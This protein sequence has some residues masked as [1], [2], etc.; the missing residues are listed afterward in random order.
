M[1]VVGL[2]SA[3]AE[4]RLAH[5]GPNELRA[6]GRSSVMAIVWRQVR[7]NFVLYLLAAAAVLSFVVEKP[8]TSYTIIAVIISVTVAGFIQEY[9]SEKATEA[10]KQLLV[11]VSIVRRN[12]KDME[13]FSRNIV[14][15]DVLVLR[16][17]EKIPADGIVVEASDLRVNES[18]LTG[19][20][21]DVS[22][23]VASD[24]HHPTPEQQIAMGTFVVYGRCLALVT[25]TGMNTKFGQISRSISESVKELPLQTKINRIAKFMVL[26]AL[27]VAVATGALMFSRADVITEEVV[28]TTLIFVIA[29]AISAFPE[30]FPVVVISTLA[31]GMRRMAK[32]NAIVNRMS[33]IETLGE[34]TVICSDKTGTIT[35]G[36][37]TVTEVWTEDHELAVTG[38]GYVGDGEFQSGTSTV[39]LKEYPGVQRLIHAAVA[40]NDAVIERTGD[41]MKFRVRGTATEAALLILGAKAGVYRDDLDLHRREEIPFNSERKMMSVIVQEGALMNVYAKGAPEMILARC[42]SIATT[43]GIRPID[44]TE[45]GRIL[46]EIHGFARRALR[47]LAIA[48]KSVA[49][50]T[51][52]HLEDGLTFLGFVGMEDTPREEV[53][54]AIADCRRAGIQVKMITG[55]NVETANAVAKQ[56]GLEGKAMVGAELE[57]MTDDELEKT[58]ES[59]SIFSRVKPEHKLRIIRALKARGHIVTMTGD[60]VNDAPALKDAHIGI[61]MG[62][63][64]TDVSR[65]VA[66][67]TLKDDNFSSIVAAVYEG[68]AI[69]KNIQKFVTYQLA[70]SIAA[71]LIL[72]FGLLF[73]PQLGWQTPILLA[74]QILFMNLVTDNLPAITLG[75]NPPSADLLSEQPRKNQEILTKSLIGLLVG[76]SVVLA[77]MALTANYIA[78]HWLQYDIV[79]ARTVAMVTLICLEISA[80]FTFRSFRKGVIGRS[81][82]V[83]RP[84]FIASV[85][86]MIATLVIIYTPFRG[87]FETA[88]IGLVGWG[89]AISCGVLLILLY[90][91]AKFLN[92]RY[93]WVELG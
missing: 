91:V 87:P 89:I 20:S 29:L 18:I 57:G 46:E 16:T 8:T 17:G 53:A 68:R 72:F 49:A 42:T 58:I 55:D 52:D 78:I 64:G 77:L 2:T 86:S 76:S 11:S 47:T 80:A 26:L 1:H 90:D 28:I 51:K 71:L 83:N 32:R 21:I 73:A 48:E 14:P 69:Y 40:C 65:S 19:E 60:G 70:C 27:V 61:A 67:L 93:R 25:H 85:I 81:L 22:K 39:A 84:L 23:T 3:E 7:G 62:K 43:S 74:L 59:I 31:V 45:R 36:E 66:D 88:G 92:N 30:G 9:R 6:I 15:G 82:F 12:G 79:A 5:Y 4:Q 63:N 41:D 44:E 75:L 35:K 50:I 33:I 10:L 24:I 37:M 13:I 34:T 56:I 54:E 38:S